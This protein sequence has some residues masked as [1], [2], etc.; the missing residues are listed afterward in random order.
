MEQ[1]KDT[2]KWYKKNTRKLLFKVHESMICENLDWP[3]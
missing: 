1:L 2:I 3:H